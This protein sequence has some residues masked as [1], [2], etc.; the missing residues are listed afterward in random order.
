MKKDEKENNLTKEE[1][2]PEPAGHSDLAQVSPVKMLSHSGEGKRR[3]QEM[4]LQGMTAT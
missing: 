4:C 1:R 2:A 3:S